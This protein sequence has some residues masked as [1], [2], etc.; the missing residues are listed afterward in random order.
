MRLPAACYR[1]QL[2]DLKAHT[3]A[4]TPADQPAK[5]EPERM[6]AIPQQASDCQVAIERQ[7]QR[8]TASD[9]HRRMAQALLALAELEGNPSDEGPTVW[10]RITHR[11]LAYVAISPISATDRIL[12]E[13]TY[14]RLITPSHGRIR[15]DDP[16]G[17][18]KVANRDDRAI[19]ATVALP[20][21]YLA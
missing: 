4:E 21:P 19:E 15:L 7:L 8:L 14:M 16:Q 12:E 20:R 6:K 2:Q 13:F 9:R 3:L 1:I 17:L 5:P 11:D 10:I 18:H